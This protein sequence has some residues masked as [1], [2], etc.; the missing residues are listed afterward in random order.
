M[1]IIT[2]GLCDPGLKWAT[3]LRNKPILIHLWRE[4]I[5]L[6]TAGICILHVCEIVDARIYENRVC[7]IMHMCKLCF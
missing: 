1:G 3:D 2:W 6:L 4:N 7:I 5:A